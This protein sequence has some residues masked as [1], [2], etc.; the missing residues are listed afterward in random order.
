MRRVDLLRMPLAVLAAAAYQLP[1]TPLTDRWGWRGVELPTRT[2]ILGLD[3]LGSFNGTEPVWVWMMSLPVLCLCV[4]SMRR[5]APWIRSGVDHVSGAEATLVVVPR[6]GLSM[7]AVALW[8]ECLSGLAE[9]EPWGVGI[10]M[11]AGA[12]P[13]ICLVDLVYAPAALVRALVNRSVS[14]SAPPPLYGVIGLRR[15]SPGAPR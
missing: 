11:V 9:S 15:A 7:A 14:P 2:P 12:A 4:D 5:W 3:L 8:W 10:Q 6:L 13:A 1:W